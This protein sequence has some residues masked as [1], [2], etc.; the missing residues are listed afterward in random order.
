MDV[1]LT[2]EVK[3]LLF[4]PCFEIAEKMGSRLDNRIRMQQNI[5]ERALTEDLID[6]LDTSSTEN[7]WGTSLSSLRERQIRI[8]TQIR[9]STIE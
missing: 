5:D 7:A 9:K 3:Q 4:H 8:S 2:D 6:A 1:W